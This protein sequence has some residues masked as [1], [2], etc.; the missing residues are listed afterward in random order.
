MR[1]TN[2]YMPT[3]R[4]DPADAE[5]VSHK[6]LVRGAFVRK[7]ETGIYSYLPLGMKVKNKIYKIVCDAMEDYDSVQVETSMIQ[8]KELWQ[9]SGRWQTFGPE[10]LKMTDRLGREYCFG[11]TAEE[12]F[13]D[14]VK[15]E[16][17]SYKQLPLNLYQIVEKFRD[18]RRPRNGIIRAR[19][20]LMK[21]AYSFDEDY[22]GLKAA[23]QKMWDAYVQAFDN[24]RIDYKIVQGDTGAM[25]G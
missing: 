9:A 16:L 23:Y 17:V 12:Y 10:M 5:V 8:P 19:S 7:Q 18:E 6:L 13:A 15:N 22:E 20:F 14:L 1:L 11:P 4:D 3:L 25:G 24:M 2:Y 21:D